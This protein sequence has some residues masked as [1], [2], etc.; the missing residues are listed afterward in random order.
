MHSDPLFCAIHFE[1]MFDAL[2][3]FI[4]MGDDQ[5]LGKEVDYFHRVEFQNHGSAHYHIFFW[6]EGVPKVVTQDTEQEVLQ[7]IDR[8]I[9]CNIVDQFVDSELHKLVTKLQSLTWQKLYEAVQIQVSLQI[10][11]GCFNSY[12]VMLRLLR[13]M[14]DFMNCKGMLIRHSSIAIIL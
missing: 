12:I 13:N 11:I 8:V 9:H 2:L 10:P 3:K 14:V 7:Y 5:P 6:I 1:R 4:I